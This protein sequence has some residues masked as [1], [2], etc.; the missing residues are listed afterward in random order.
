MAKRFRPRPTRPSHSRPRLSVRFPRWMM[1]TIAMLGVLFGGLY[2]LDVKLRPMV[3]TA[4]TALAHKAGSEALNEALTDEIMAY[5]ARGPLLDTT[6]DKQAGNFT[7]TRV[8]MAAVTKLQGDVT[9]QAQARLQ[10]LSSQSIRLPLIRMFSG[11]LLSKSTLTIP[12]RMSMLG[13]VHSSIESEV[14]TKGVNQVV[15]IIYVHVTADIMVITPV[16]TTPITVDSRA[17]VAYLVMAGPV[18]SAYYGP[19]LFSKSNSGLASPPQS[20]R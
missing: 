6:V 8:N 7:I 3:T 16:V 15:H 14:Q 19:E 5:G 9:R 18:P 12:V 10:A 20:S 13:A 4:S 2:L 1:S 11:S 17:P